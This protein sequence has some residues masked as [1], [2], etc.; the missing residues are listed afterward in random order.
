MYSCVGSF[1]FAYLTHKRSWCKIQHR[2]ENVRHRYLIFKYPRICMLKLASYKTYGTN[3][4]F[5]TSNLM[6]FLAI[7][8]HFVI[9]RTTHAPTMVR[10]NA[11]LD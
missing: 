1:A 8:R 2:E 3:H 9:A 10:G 6:C 5:E 4:M 11:C 7:Y